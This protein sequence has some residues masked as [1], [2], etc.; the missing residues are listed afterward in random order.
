MHIKGKLDNMEKQ[1]KT[2]NLNNQGINSSNTG[3]E[4]SLQRCV[5]VKEGYG[6][7]IDHL[8][9]PWWAEQHL[10]MLKKH[11]YDS[12]SFPQPFISV[13][14]NFSLCRWQMYSMIL[15]LI[16]LFVVFVASVSGVLLAD[17]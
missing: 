3:S 10:K 14:T 8:L 12:T 4:F 9:Q 7:S 1:N 6:N 11:Y 2:K 13:S 16:C 15:F 17:L 5:F